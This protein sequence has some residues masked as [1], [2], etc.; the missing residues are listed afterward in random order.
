M[1]VKTQ[2][3]PLLSICIPSKGDR[4]DILRATLNSIFTNN[5]VPDGDFEVILSCNSTESAIQEIVKE[6]SKF[7]NFHFHQ[8]NANGFLNSVSALRTGNGKLLKLHNDYTLLKPGSL[9]LLLT[10]IRNY[11]KRK[12]FIF[13]SQGEMKVNSEIY[14]N[15]FESFIRKATFLISW[16]TGFSI[17]RDDLERIEDFDSLDK[18]FPHT[19]ILLKVNYKELYIINDLNYFQN[20]EVG[21]KG[22]YNL[23][24]VFSVNFLRLIEESFKNGDLTLK[25]LR[26]VKRKL[27]LNFLIPWYF[28]TKIKRNN[29]TFDLTDIKSNVL[30]YYTIWDYYLMIILAYLLPA[31]LAL[32]KTAR[33]LIKN[34]MKK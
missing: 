34:L 19:S 8:S 21:S 1:K 6:Y 15:Q 11:E 5:S 10:L 24:N 30:V 7:H 2:N 33:I 25:A 17:W 14:S 20:Q 22:G 28:R 4:N 12:P 31:K 32:N 9:E 16:S 29:F 23:F 18:M 3:Q 13:F 26:I 27:Y